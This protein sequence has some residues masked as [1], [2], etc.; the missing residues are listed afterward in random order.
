MAATPMLNWERALLALFE[1]AVVVLDVE[2]LVVGPALQTY[3]QNQ[4]ETITSNHRPRGTT[5]GSA[6]CR[7]SRGRRSRHRKRFG[8]TGG[9]S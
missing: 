9:V 8:Q 7:S 4:E 6:G 2:V 1:V 3:E 5:A